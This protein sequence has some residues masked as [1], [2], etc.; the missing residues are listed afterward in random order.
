MSNA[1]TMTPNVG[2]VILHGKPE[3]EVYI[4]KS[5]LFI[6]ETAQENANML[7]STVYASGGPATHDQPAVELSVGAEVATFKNKAMRFSFAGAEYFLVRLD[8]VLFAVN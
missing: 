6:P 7:F 3:E 5:G 1:M 8:D 4:N 2:Y